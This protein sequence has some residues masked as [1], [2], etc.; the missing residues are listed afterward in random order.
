MKIIKSIKVIFLSLVLFNSSFAEI[1]NKEINELISKLEQNL[2]T[3]EVTKASSLLKENIEIIDKINPILNT[4]TKEDKIE[5]FSSLTDNL[6]EFKANIFLKILSKDFENKSN[7]EDLS[8]ANQQKLDNL[9]IKVVDVSYKNEK[10]SHDGAYEIAKIISKAPVNLANNLVNIT[11]RIA[12]Q[13][14][15][16]NNFSSNILYQI[17]KIDPDKVNQL[18]VEVTND[19]IKQSLKEVENEIVLKKAKVN[20]NINEEN[21]LNINSLTAISSAIISSNINLSKKITENISNISKNKLE[22]VTFKLVEQTNALENWNVVANKNVIESKLNFVEKI[23]PTAFTNIDLNKIEKAVSIIQTSDTKVANKT[24]EAIVNSYVENNNNFFKVNNKF[25]E[26]T[27]DLFASNKINKTQFIKSNQQ[28]E[29][30]LKSLYQDEISS[31][32][33]Q[34]PQMSYIFSALPVSNFALANASPN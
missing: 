30:F 10:E 23:Y 21:D 29:F 14:D 18:E 32:V 17:N 3:Y 25:L 15:N 11:C 20:N 12:E 13:N 33:F 27:Q 28:G 24:V 9:L 5:L 22:E 26:R 16:S 2:K 7:L 34:D 1:N 31:V 6:D 4:I 19:L 8:I